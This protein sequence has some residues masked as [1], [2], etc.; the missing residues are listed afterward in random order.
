MTSENTLSQTGSGDTAPMGHFLGRSLARRGKELLVAADIATRVPQLEELE[1]YFL[2]KELGVESAVPI[3]RHAT[4]AQLQAIVDLDCW[5]GDYLDIDDLDVW[6]APFAAEGK[7]VLVEAF[8]NLEDEIQVL[9]LAGI[10]DV[11]DAE[12]EEP[13]EK[14]K[15]G[16]LMTTMDGFL[17]LEPT[18]GDREIDPFFLVDGLY[19]HDPNTG[20]RLLMAAKWELPSPLTEQARTFRTA[21][22]SEMG[23]PNPEEA[24]GIFAS[25]PKTPP[26][27]HRGRQLSPLTRLP[28]LYASSVDKGDSLLARALNRVSDQVILESVE[29]SLVY[30]INTAVVAWGHGPKELAFVKLIAARVRDT[31]SL[32]LEVALSPDE[33]LGNLDSEQVAQDAARLFDIW[34]IQNI[35]RHGH[36][37]VMSVQAAARRLA[38]DPIV[39]AWLK[40]LAQSDDDFSADL[41]DRLFMQSLL[42]KRPLYAAFD[43]MQPQVNKAF[44]SQTEIAAAFARIDEL[45][46]RL[47]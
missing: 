13:P 38:H 23:F 6:L 8:L 26:K 24:I 5:N 9:F 42:Q 37:R 40:P 45:A 19:R 36:A 33:P 20:F 4:P 18:P 29:I 30:L 2:V 25:P 34:S 35:F 43:S 16:R 47:I 28:A 39:E 1:T 12:E 14:D 22:V 32:G 41:G 21:R 7:E 44:G 31:L 46:E 17:I 3:L 15:D 11:Y 27:L 10:V